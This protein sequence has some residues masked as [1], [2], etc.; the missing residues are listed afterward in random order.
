MTID[1]ALELSD[2]NFM[3]VYGSEYQDYALESD[4]GGIS[5]ECPACGERT[6]EKVYLCKAAGNQPTTA[7]C[8]T[9]GKR[10]CLWRMTARCYKA[11]E[12]N[13]C[14]R[15]GHTEELK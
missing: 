8:Y 12:V 14:T 11:K 7:Y 10:G 1:R 2:G 15:C 6:M 3:T 4:E 9:Q 13:R 5:P